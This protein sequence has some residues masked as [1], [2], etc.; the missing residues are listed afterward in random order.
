MS[1]IVVGS[2]RSAGATTLTLALAGWLTDAVLVEADPQGG[3]LAMRYGLCREPGLVTLAASRDLSARAILDH[4]Q[5]L[6]GDLAV[7]VG[8]ESPERATHMLRNAGD[9]LAGLLARSSDFNIV[10]DA[11]RLSP[12]SPALCLVPAASATLVVARPRADELVAAAERVAALGPGAGLVLVGSGPY[13]PSEVA[14]QLGCP[15]VA[16]IAD[17]PRSARSLAEGGSAR[18][19]SRSPLLRSVRFLAATLARALGSGPPEYQE[20]LERSGMAT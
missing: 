3:V 8:S 7:V 18:A 9:R 4:A 20:R 19:L 10:V 5:R 2:V 15:V 11:G 12:F 17:D 1:V 13:R 14:A 6:P 16:T